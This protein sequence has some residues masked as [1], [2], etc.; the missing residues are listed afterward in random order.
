MQNASGGA[1]ATPALATRAQSTATRFQRARPGR[2]RSRAGALRARSGSP[3]R[4]RDAGA[5][6]AVPSPA[7]QVC[8]QVSGCNHMSCRCGA[9]WC[10]GC[11]KVTESARACRNF[12][13]QQVGKPGFSGAGTSTWTIQHR[14]HG[15][16]GCPC[17]C[18][19]CQTLAVKISPPSFLW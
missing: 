17:L 16:F 15:N 4:A 10:F 8:L 1:S 14:K 12:S 13:R 7:S 11:G 3:D 5:C 6:S 19:G 9:H 2:F 18:V